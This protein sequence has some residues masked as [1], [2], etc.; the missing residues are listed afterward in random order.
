MHFRIHGVIDKFVKISL[1]VKSGYYFSI[2]SLKVMCTKKLFP[3]EE[4][5]GGES[6][7]GKGVENFS[8]LINKGD[9]FFPG[10]TPV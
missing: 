10:E 4:G 3:N 2:F 9:I 7:E 5:G 6:F 1:H 8:L